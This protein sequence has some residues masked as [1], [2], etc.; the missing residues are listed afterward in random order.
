MR[1][2]GA[3]GG[4]ENG[5]GNRASSACPAWLCCG[6]STPASISAVSASP[7]SAASVRSRNRNRLITTARRIIDDGLGGGTWAACAC[8]CPDPPLCS[9]REASTAANRKHRWSPDTT[10]SRFGTC[11]AGAEKGCERRDVTNSLRKRRFL[12]A[13]D[14]VSNPSTSVEARLR[15]RSGLGRRGSVLIGKLR[16]SNPAVIWWMGVKTR[17]GV[18]PTDAA[19][20]APAVATE[21]DFAV[22]N[23]GPVLP[24]ETCICGFSAASGFSLM[25]RG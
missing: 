25:G 7:R 16:I 4:W 21:T 2:I 20:F 22:A 1:R 19:P 12:Q 18:S 17:T 5:N 9:R 11:V 14:A 10:H 6:R 3:V 8:G 15:F 13:S 23:T 24:F